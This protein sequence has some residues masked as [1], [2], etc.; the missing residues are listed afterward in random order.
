MAADV[1]LKAL[2]RLTFVLATETRQT[3]WCM[4]YTIRSI[5][6]ASHQDGVLTIFRQF[7]NNDDHGTLFALPEHQQRMY[8]CGESLE[9]PDNNLAAKYSRSGL[10]ERGGPLVRDVLVQDET[11]R[12][13]GWRHD[14]T[15]LSAGCSRR[16]NAGAKVSTRPADIRTALAHSALSLKYI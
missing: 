9:T 1:K 14:Q 11:E 2:N 8:R 6:V 5:F 4:Q 16:H 10:A 15:L 12:S 13:D 3:L 7:C